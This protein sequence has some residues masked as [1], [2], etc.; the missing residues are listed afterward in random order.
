MIKKKNKLQKLRDELDEHQLIL[1]NLRDQ[2]VRMMDNF[3]DRIKMKI[4]DVNTL[5]AELIEANRKYQKS[6]Q[7]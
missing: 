7:K 1:R 6:A 3:D 2:K 4:A 5:R